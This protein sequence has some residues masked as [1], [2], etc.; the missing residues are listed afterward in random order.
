M[1]PHQRS[2]PPIF[3]ERPTDEGETNRPYDAE[4][5]SVGPEHDRVVPSAKQ[6]FSTCPERALSERPNK[7]TSGDENKDQSDRPREDI[8]HSNPRHVVS[9]AQIRLTVQLS[10]SKVRR[11]NPCGI[12]RPR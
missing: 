2:P 11:R 4:P 5:G 3:Q 9:V 12:L 6:T 1:V 10:S 8:G 7:R